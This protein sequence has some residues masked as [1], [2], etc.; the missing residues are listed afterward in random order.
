[1][2]DFIKI[3]LVLCAM[4][5]AFVYGRNYGEENFRQSDEF[6][7][8]VKSKEEQNFTKNDLE[9]AKTKFQNIL[10]S[11]DVK[12]SEELL[13]QV[14]QVLTNDFG[15]KIKDQNSFI[16]QASIAM[17]IETPIKKE[18]IA[19]KE[20]V[21]DYKRIKSYEW[22]LKNSRDGAEL[23]A[24]LKNVEIKDIDSFLKKATISELGQRESLIGS[25]RGRIMDVTQNEYA[26]LAFNINPLKSSIKI[27]R[28][29]KEASAKDF[30]TNELGLQVEGS[31]SIIIDNGT[32]YYQLYKIADTQQI[33]GYYYE[34]LVNGTTK[35]IGSFVLNR[36]D[37]F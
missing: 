28:N 22:I 8:F 13:A 17:P 36:V 16:K 7:G 14:L 3:F 30:E 4:V 27:F 12:K 26:T 1:M 10:D 11:A 33:A 29:E 25:Y 5:G 32:T 23:K 37:Q 6:R 34:R 15:L 21:F 18:V 20:K 35:T 2:K 19:K 31:S 24:N 9:N